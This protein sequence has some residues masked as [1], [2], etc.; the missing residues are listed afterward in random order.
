MK[1]KS[2]EVFEIVEKRCE[3]FFEGDFIISHAGKHV[4]V[5]LKRDNTFL[6]NHLYYDVS[7][8]MGDNKGEQKR[9]LA[10]ELALTHPTRKVLVFKG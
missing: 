1:K 8:I 3:N 7:Y 5:I 9:Y 2:G 10:S 4:Y 6:H